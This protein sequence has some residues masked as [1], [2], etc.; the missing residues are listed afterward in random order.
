MPDYDETP[1]E[2]YFPITK[3]QPE[4]IDGI[5]RGLSLLAIAMVLI[6][7]VSHHVQQVNETNRDRKDCVRLHRDA[8]IELGAWRALQE[9]VGTEPFVLQRTRMQ[10]ILRRDCN[11]RYPDPKILF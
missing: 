2:R 7:G 11:K 1:T 6:L 4:P 3:S 9:Q 5:A 8:V 10:S